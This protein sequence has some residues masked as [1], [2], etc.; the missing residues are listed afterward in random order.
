[1]STPES[2]T[3]LPCVEQPAFGAFDTDGD[4]VLSISELK[5]ADPNNAQLQEVSSALEA[6]GIAGLRY[7]GCEDGANEGTTSG[8]DLAQ[9]IARAAV[10]R[11]EGD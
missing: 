7:Q 8:E 4:G 9:I 2:V 10:A 11:L 3:N 5:A 6:A 1:M